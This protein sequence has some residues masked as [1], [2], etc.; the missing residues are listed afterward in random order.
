MTEVS[1]KR[2]GFSL[3]RLP[4]LTSMALKSVA[5]GNQGNLVFS[6]LD[7]ARRKYRRFHQL[8]PLPRGLLR[9]SYKL[10]FLAKVCLLDLSDYVAVWELAEIT[11]SKP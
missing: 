8:L 1:T 2:I 4:S 6:T 7:P 10:S 3:F 9:N 5:P 11:D